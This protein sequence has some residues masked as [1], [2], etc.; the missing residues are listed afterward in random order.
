MMAIEKFEIDISSFA[1]RNDTM[2]RTAPSPKPMVANGI[3][4][5][6]SER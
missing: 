2:G 1:P 6:M 4:A 3:R 5:V